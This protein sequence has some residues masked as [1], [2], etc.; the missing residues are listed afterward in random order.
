ML[1]SLEFFVVTAHAR[2]VCRVRQTIALKYFEESVVV[3]AH[4]AVGLDNRAAHKLSALPIA[5]H[6]LDVELKGLPSVTDR[7]DVLGPV[8]QIKIAPV[9]HEHHAAAVAVIAHAKG[10]TEGVFTGRHA[11][12]FAEEEE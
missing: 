3:A 4:R 12:L 8:L 6:P 5:V 10:F 7:R 11:I 9:D 1:S 2:D